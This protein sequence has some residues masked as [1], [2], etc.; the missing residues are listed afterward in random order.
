MKP[1]GDS[2]RGGFSLIELLVSVAVV[3]VLIALLA[4]GVQGVRAVAAN[5]Q[6]VNNLRQM[7]LG[8]CQFLEVSGRF[9]TYAWSIDILPFIGQDGASQRFR[10][11]VDFDALIHA[12]TVVIPTYLCP[13]DL[14][15]TGLPVTSYHG[16]AGKLSCDTWDGALGRRATDITD[17]LSNTLIVGERPPTPTAERFWFHNYLWTINES[18]CTLYYDSSGDQGPGEGD[19]GTPCPDRTYFSPGDLTTYCH[20]NHFWSFHAGGGNWLLC[21]ASV[22]FMSYTLGTTVIPIMA[23]AAGGEVIPPL[24]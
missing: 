12:E 1:A 13:A 24:D 9:P 6:C 14:R 4:A 15:D 11:S 18:P 19:H 20:G 2:I 3:A 7:G 10:N 8:L 22:R 21:D 23:T 17:G 16:I 5:A